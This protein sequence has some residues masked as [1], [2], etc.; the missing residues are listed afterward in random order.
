VARSTVGFHTPP[1]AL[2]INL[3]TDNRTANAMNAGRPELLRA[4]YRCGSDLAQYEQVKVS[5]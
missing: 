5:K 4:F 1:V 3:S 2:S